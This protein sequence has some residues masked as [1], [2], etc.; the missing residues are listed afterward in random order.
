MHAEV[1]E[2]TLSLAEGEPD[3]YMHKDSLP[4]PLQCCLAYTG[5]LGP[6]HDS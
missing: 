2:M 4:G 3:F 6:A 1:G 5:D